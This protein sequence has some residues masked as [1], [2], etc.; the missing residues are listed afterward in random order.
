MVHLRT[1]LYNIILACGISI[2]GKNSVRNL[3]LFKNKITKRVSPIDI[4]DEE[5]NDGESSFFTGIFIL[6]IYFQMLIK[7][8]AAFE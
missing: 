2:L 6:K 3:F 7:S 5:L 1:L 4:T 8:F